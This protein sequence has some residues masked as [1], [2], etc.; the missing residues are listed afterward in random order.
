[1]EFSALGITLDDF[2]EPWMKTNPNYCMIDAIL[3][4]PPKKA[5]VDLCDRF[6]SYD[7]T[8]IYIGTNVYNGTSDSLALLQISPTLLLLDLRPGPRSGRDLSLWTNLLLVSASALRPTKASA[9]P[10]FSKA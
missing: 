3:S 1:M 2:P 10:A 4:V 6:G 9:L 7:G 5:K 8:N